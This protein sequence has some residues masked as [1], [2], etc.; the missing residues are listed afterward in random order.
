MRPPFQI[1][2]KIEGETLTVPEFMH[3]LAYLARVY[4]VGKVSP[5]E[6][7]LSV[8]VN[9]AFDWLDTHI[10][11]GQYGDIHVYDISWARDHEPTLLRTLPSSRRRV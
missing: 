10:G 11:D 5:V 7:A 3:S 9:E 2:I 6:Q 8:D 1:E 4:K